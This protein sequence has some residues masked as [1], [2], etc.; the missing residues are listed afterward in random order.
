MTTESGIPAHYPARTPSP[1]APRFSSAAKLAT[2]PMLR[3]PFI[4][5]ASS[6]LCRIGIW[7]SGGGTGFRLTL[8]GD[9]ILGLPSAWWS[10]DGSLASVCVVVLLDNP[11]RL[12]R[13]WLLAEENEGD[14]WCRLPGWTWRLRLP[15]TGEPIVR[16]SI[17]GCR[18]L[19]V[20]RRSGVLG[21]SAPWLFFELKGFIQREKEWSLL[22]LA[23]IVAD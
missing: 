11:G 2:L 14:V 22:P 13:L 7:S 20:D 4:P 19:D 10:S 16:W 17:D 3:L 12:G 5:L 1:T 8:R 21:A 18:L 15:E 6:S 23:G 9:D